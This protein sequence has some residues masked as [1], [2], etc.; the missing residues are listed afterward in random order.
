MSQHFALVREAAERFVLNLDEDD[1]ARI[2]SFSNHVQV[3]P[4]EF[5]SDQDAL[6]RILRENLQDEG[7]TPLWNATAAAMRR[8]GAGTGPPRRSDVHGWL[9]Q[10]AAAGLEHPVA[11][12]RDRA[13]VEE[14]MVYGIGL[15]ES[16]RRQPHRGSVG[17]R[18]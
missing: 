16:A 9:R 5:T 6:I 14:V 3:D 18:R 13:Q 2:G 7:P 17:S 1:R 12:V 4:P 11:A 15:A 10:P 8:P